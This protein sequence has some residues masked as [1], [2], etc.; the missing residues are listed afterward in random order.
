MD[1]GARGATVHW[2]AK[3]Q[4]KTERLTLSLFSFVIYIKYYVL[5]A[6]SSTLSKTVHFILRDIP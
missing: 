1:R 4:K 2:V 3:S 6:K 5:G